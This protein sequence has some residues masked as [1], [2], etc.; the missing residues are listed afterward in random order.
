MSAEKSPL[1]DFLTL[2]PVVARLRDVY[3]AFHDRRASLGLSNPGTIEKI[4]QE[5]QRDVFLNNYAFTGLRADITKAFSVMPMFQ[6]SHSLSMGSQMLPPYGFAALYG[7]SKVFMQANLDSDLSLNGRFNYRWSSSFITKTSVQLAQGQA[8]ANFEN[9]YTGADFSASLKMMNPSILDGGLTGIFV[10]SYLQSLTPRFALGLEGVWQRA[11]MNRGP[12]ML[13][14]YAAKY[15]GDDWIA[16]AQLLAAGG[17]SASYWRRLTERVETGVDVSLQFAG[18]GMA[19]GGMMSSVKKEG[20]TTIGAKY[21]F[22][23]SSFRAQI[24][25]Q[26]KLGCLLEKRV[27]PQVQV[28]FAGE[29]DHPKNTAKVGLAVSLEAADEDVMAQQ[30]R[31][32]EVASPPF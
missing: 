28:T 16:S 1:P 32:G 15:K 27:A 20:V 3:N 29:I 2:N 22:R 17:I 6:V 4:A 26:G 8:M 9:D 30:E 24:D 25:S 21:D 5:V 18:L 7:S 12:E 10:G 11:A 19:P 13:V 31:T 14:S 23:A